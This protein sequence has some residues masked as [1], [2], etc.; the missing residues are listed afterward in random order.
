MQGEVG[1]SKRGIFSPSPLP[2]LFSHRGAGKQG[3]VVGG[4]GGRIG[5]VV[6]RTTPSGMKREGGVGRRRKKKGE[7]GEKENE[8]CPF[9]MDGK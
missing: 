7:K 8:H 2:L 3:M 6:E 1:N 5:V 9:Q 4:K